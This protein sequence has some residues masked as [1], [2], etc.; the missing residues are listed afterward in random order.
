MSCYGDERHLINTPNL[1]SI[2]RNGM[3]FDRCLVTNS[4][5]GPS[6]AT[7]LTGV[8][9]HV[10]GFYDNTVSRFDGSQITFPKLLQAAGYQTAMIGKWHLV[11]DPT[12]FDFWQILI[13]QGRYYDPPM[14][15]NGKRIATEGYV[16]DVVTDASIEWLKNR[17]KTRPFLLMSQHKSAHRPWEANISDFNFDNGATYQEP[18]T[19]FDDYATRGPG[20]RATK[21]TI[22]NDID[23][24]DMKLATPRDIPQRLRAQW[25]AHY[26]PLNKAG[27]GSALEG[28]AL[29]SWKY[30]RFMHEYLGSVYGL[31]K[32]VGRLLDY[33]KR[34]GLLE[35]TIIIYASDQ[36]FFL[37]EHGWFDKRW[38]Y[39]EALR[40]PFVMSW[41]GVIKPGSVNKDMVSNLDFAPTLLEAA[42][43]PV[44]A[45]M[46][47]RSLLPLL[48]GERPPAPWRTS[49]YYQFHEDLYGVPPHYGVVTD[50]YKLMHILSPKYDYW[51]MFD[52]QTDPRELKNIYDDPASAG[53]RA[54]LAAE[55]ARLRAEL[56]VPDKPYVMPARP[57]AKKSKNAN[58]KK[59]TA[60]NAEQ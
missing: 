55:L 56:R 54:T 41:P 59:D 19:L 42:G 60:I 18:P 50:R 30:Q 14:I 51:E 20:E 1:D 36:G 29:T 48:K 7:V 5:C 44:P 52:L 53:Q 39:E 34:E 25:E 9:S 27:D 57:A 37:G 22:A 47:G 49:F 28:R 16:S 26:N 8:Y 15:R 24:N 11:T 3:R 13:D 58:A 38:F 33:L 43:V 12:G 32:S 6:R 17:D 45:R 4:L 2:A 46:Q 10:N 23:A 31:D 21:I 35:N 40:T